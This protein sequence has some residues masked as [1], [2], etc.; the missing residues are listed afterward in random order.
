MTAPTQLPA[1][2]DCWFY[3][4]MDIPNVGTVSA[5]NGWDLR[6]RFDDYV[7]CIPVAGKTLLD[8]GTA[9]GFLTFEAEQRG[10]SV[11]SFDV[12]SAGQIESINPPIA[13]NPALD[14]HKTNELRMMRNAYWFAHHHFGS[15]AKAV[16]GDIYKLPAHVQPHDIVLIGQVLVHLQNPLEA[17]RQASFVAKETLIITEGSYNSHNPS[18]VF[19]GAGGAGVIYGFW[20]LSDQIYKAWL[21][22]LGFEVV[23]ISPQ[24]YRCNVPTM[25]RDVDVWTFVAERRTPLGP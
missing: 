1:I 22:R 4:Q 15:R 14:T 12:A 8:V 13:V 10:A 3:H 9:G 21:D 6:G 7:A 17:I 2:E 23:T 24:K 19:L 25:E 11:T 18:A 16:Y 5:P 20:H